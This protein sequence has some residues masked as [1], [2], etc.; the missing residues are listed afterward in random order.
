MRRGRNK[1][2]RQPGGKRQEAGPRHKFGKGGG[3]RHGKPSNRH[4]D[5]RGAERR[6]SKGDGPKHRGRSSFEAHTK[7]VED[8]RE[9]AYGRAPQ[10]DGERERAPLR[11]KKRRRDRTGGP[12][13]KYPKGKD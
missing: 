12:R 13:P 3:K 9:R 5:E 11:K 2:P 8:A 7:R 4:P 10:D 6:A 1:P